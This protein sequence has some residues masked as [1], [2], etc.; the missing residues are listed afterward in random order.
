MSLRNQVIRLAHANPALRPHLLP[1]LGTVQKVAISEET[2]DFVEWVINTQAPVPENR[3]ETF[4]TGTLKMKILPPITKREGP[5]FIKGDRVLVRE[6]KHKE[7]A[8]IAPY[9]EFNGKTGVVVDTEGLDALVQ[10]DTGPKAPVRFPNALKPRGV[11]LM[12]YTPPFT[13]E[14]SDKI[15]MVYFT[16]PDA[17]VNE[18]QQ[19]VV[20]QY[21]GRARKGEKR[22]ATYYTGYLFS[23]RT[24]AA[25]EVY[26]QA[27]PQQRQQVDPQS[28]GGYQ[29]R[30]FNPTKGKVLY[31]G[32]FGKRPSGWKAELEQL[33][34]SSADAAGEDAEE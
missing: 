26:F 7:P 2:S 25:G 6:D 11:G 22:P 31:I 23:A 34:A 1:L 13:L 8:T 32:L 20:T 3:I 10:L 27:F 5:R 15:E 30:S 28:E 18:E 21:Q 12:K 33:R 9:A 19:L 4:L 16:N 24:N 17:K 14:G 29:A